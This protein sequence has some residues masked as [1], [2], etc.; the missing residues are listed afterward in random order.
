MVE[1]NGRHSEWPACA[2]SLPGGLTDDP[3][4]KLHACLSSTVAT[5]AKNDRLTWGSRQKRQRSSA[6]FPSPACK[7]EKGD[8]RYGTLDAEASIR[9]TRGHG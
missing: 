5:R 8:G 2:P 1:G 4:D 3:F 6:Q 9:G 7:R